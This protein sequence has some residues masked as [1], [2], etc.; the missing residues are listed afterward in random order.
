M[1]LMLPLLM[2]CL[3]AACTM[4]VLSYP[5]AP[6]PNACGAAG[7][8][9]LIGLSATVIPPTGV[10]S[11]IRIIHPGELVSLE[12]SASRLNV[13]VDALNRIVQITCG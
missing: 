13:R 12:Y 7:L 2:T 4:P 6:N 5:P 3:L 8:Q 10:W 9:G 11:T 1:R